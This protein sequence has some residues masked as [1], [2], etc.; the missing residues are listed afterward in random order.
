MKK[1]TILFVGL[2]VVVSLILGIHNAT[3]YAPS[4]GFDGSGHVFYIEY[5]ASNWKIPPV[6][7][8]WETHQSPLYYFLGAALMKISG[9][10][11]TAQYMNTFILWMLILISCFGIW[12]VYK[13]WTPVIFGGLALAAL[14]ML[15]IFPAMVTNELLNTFWIISV[16]VASIYI[17]EAK[18]KFEVNKY[19][20]IATILFVLGIWTKISV[21]M[22]LPTILLAIFIAFLKQKN[23]RVNIIATTIVCIF[24]TYFLAIPIFDRSKDANGPS[25]LGKV[26]AK[27]SAVNT[28]HF[29]DFYYRMDWIWKV[30]MYNTQYYSLW[31]G[32]WN[33]FWTDG[34]NAITPF[35]KFHKKSFILWSLGF[36]LLPISL[37][38]QWRLRKTNRHVFYV[39]AM[40]GLS[41]LGTYIFYNLGKHHYS[42]VRL[43]YEMGI[44][45]PYA[46]G[47]AQIGSDIKDK[48]ISLKNLTLI[49]LIIQFAIMV[50]FYWILDWWHVTK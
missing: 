21:V 27:N 26:I 28:N 25:N 34:H 9:T 38:G 45:L 46:F 41:M 44:V 49:L 6:R 19:I 10:W 29:T 7:L 32:A 50:S 5:V 42:G 2:I 12:K 37:Y 4:H 22:I 39:I 1:I 47:I 16:A 3:L 14:P 30:D 33:S 17:V 11:K 23:I 18:T 8:N 20:F 24:L 31:G 13:K 40:M 36:I 35:V 15:N 48:K 43:T